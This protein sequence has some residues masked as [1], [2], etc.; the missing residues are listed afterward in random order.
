MVA[1]IY[2]DDQM[3]SRV[4]P[5]H[6]LG[7][8][9]D[10]V[11][12]LEEALKLSGLGGWEVAKAPLYTKLPSKR[13]WITSTEEVE[14]KGKFATYRTDTNKVLGTVGKSYRVVQNEELFDLA[15]DLLDSG[16]AKY[17]TAGSIRSN[18][19]VFITVRLERPMKIADVDFEPYLVLASSHDGS[20]S[21]RAMVTPTVVVCANTLRLA[22]NNAKYEYRIKHTNSANVRLNQVREALGMTFDT[23]DLFELEIDKLISTDVTRPQFEKIVEGLFPDSESVRGTTMATTRREEVRATYMHD[24]AAAPYQGTAWGVIN[25][26]NTWETWEKPVRS[27]STIDNAQN[28]RLER[29]AW[30]HLNGNQM[31]YTAQ[32]QAM[33]KELT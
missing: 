17:E 18:R 21:A 24:P 11:L 3:F 29:I 33:V 28:A 19:V 7:V 8:V 26:V 6:G 32:A 27:T 5:W 9:T 14:L 16:E 31:P 30:S 12:G 1:E 2:K 22:M 23:Y 15:E 25:A 13:Q 10:R 20:L 4:T